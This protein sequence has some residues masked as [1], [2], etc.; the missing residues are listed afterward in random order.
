MALKK[1]ENIPTLSK[2]GYKSI[3]SYYDP[4]EYSKKN[5]NDFYIHGLSDD[6]YELKMPLPPHRQSTHSLLFVL[7]GSLIASSGFDD[8]T[9]YQ[10]SMIVIPAGQVSSLSFMS[11]DIKGFYLHF[12]NSYLSQQEDLDFSEWLIKPI[13]KFDK[14][15]TDHLLLLLK[16][17]QQLNENEMNSN[18]IKLYLATFLAEIKQSVDFGIKANFLSHER[19]TL[20]FKKLLNFNITKHRSVSFYANELNISPNH[21]NRSVRLTLGRSASSL[22]DEMLILEARILMQKSNMAISEIAFEI[23]FDDASYFGRF[24]KKHTGIAPTDYRK[25]LELS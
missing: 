25:T 14:T 18:I 16:R 21:L 23:G 8:Y 9:L 24:F 17:M 20:G 10:N 2:D 7:E 19:I 4:I 13:V 11:D 3:M 5:I 1:I 6:T 12:T 22:I 15:E